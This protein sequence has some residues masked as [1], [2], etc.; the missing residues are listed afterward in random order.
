MVGWSKAA[1]MALTGDAIDAQA[2][3]ACGL[4]SQVVDDADLINAARSLAMRIAVNP[5]HAVR[6][7]KRLLWESRTAELATILEMASAMQATAHAT[8]D[9]EEAVNAFIEKRKPDFKGM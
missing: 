7:T 3:L 4:V 8:P 9:H 1:E 5:T 2:A 6:M